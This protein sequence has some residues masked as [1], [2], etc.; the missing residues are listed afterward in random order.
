MA[1][2]LLSTA[3]KSR[4]GMAKQVIIDVY[5]ALGRL[6]TVVRACFYKRTM[7]RTMLRD[8][9]VSVDMDS[10]NSYSS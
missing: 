6:H 3:V 5:S 8:I 2:R 1:S 10:I 4:V 7:G 9:I